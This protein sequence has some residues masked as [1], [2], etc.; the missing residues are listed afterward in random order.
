MALYQVDGVT[1]VQ[2]ATKLQECKISFKEV[3]ELKK[4]RG[5]FHISHWIDLSSERDRNKFRLAMDTEPLHVRGNPR[6]GFTL[7]YYAGYKG[8]TIQDLDEV[9]GIMKEGRVIE[10]TMVTLNAEI[11][12][13]LEVIIHKPY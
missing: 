6:K 2:I 8:K 4:M 12:S 13:D 10:R 9:T 11:S 5:S 7:Y 3:E 1:Y